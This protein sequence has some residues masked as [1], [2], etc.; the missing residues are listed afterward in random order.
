MQHC[1]KIHKWRTCEKIEIFH[2]HIISHNFTQFRTKIFT[3]FHIIFYIKLLD[4]MCAILPAGCAWQACEKVP[5]FHKQHVKK[6]LIFTRA[7][8]KKPRYFT[9]SICEKT[10]YMH[11]Y[12]D[13]KLYFPA[14]EKFR[15]IYKSLILGMCER[16]GR[17]LGQQKGYP[18]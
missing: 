17:T 3:Q 18:K 6:S 16:V 1:E 13:I 9:R 2:N 8:V 5:I 10:P 11:K 12:R 7:H 15:Y 4:S 14:R